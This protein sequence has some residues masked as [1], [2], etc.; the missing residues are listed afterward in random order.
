MSTPTCFSGVRLIEGD[1]GDA[2]AAL[3]L[4]QVDV[5]VVFDDERHPLEF[6]DELI[7]EHL[8]DDPMLLALSEG[9]PAARCERVPLTELHDAE[10]IQGAGEE[11]PASLILV[12][13]CQTAGFVP[14]TAFNTGTL[15]SCRSLWRAPSASRWF[16]RSR[17]SG[18][19][20]VWLCDRCVRTAR[21]G[22]SGLRIAARTAMKHTRTRRW[23]R[24]AKRRRGDP[25]LCDGPARPAARGLR[26][27]FD[28]RIATV[29]C[30]VADAI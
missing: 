4:R 9:H 3:R 15:A 18:R 22:A 10:W 7:A 17:S 21:V 30:P 6:G 14:R 25:A 26:S 11:T 13:A 19:I 1:P 5:A 24:C 2:L 16:P 28:G 8:V 20:R 27:S 12:A 29:A 23:P